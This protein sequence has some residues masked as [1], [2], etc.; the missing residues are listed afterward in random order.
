[1]LAGNKAGGNLVG[2]MPTPLCLVLETSTDPGS[3]V[4]AREI[5]GVII[6]GRE[7][8]SD[9]RHNAALFAPLGAMLE[10]FRESGEIMRVLVGAGPGSYSGARVGLAAAQG[11]AIAFGCPA[12]AVPSIPA[13]EFPDAEA[14]GDGAPDHCRLVIGDA[15]RGHFWHAALRGRR[16]VAA[17]ELVDSR[18]LAAIV[19]AAVNANQTVLT[20]DS[21]AVFDLP[22]E[23]L[24]H[25]AQTHPSATGLWTAWQAADAAQRDAWSD[26]PPQPVY[27][28]PPHITA[29]KRSLA[30]G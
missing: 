20:F 7:F 2:V 8:A 13:A 17:P 14:S 11:V 21:T 26:A 16:M 19:A 10:N 9:R 27:L 3:A 5:D 1:V 18:A 15:R 12:V 25:V 6:A 23:H 22:G 29:P 4:L 24:A 30:G 28:K